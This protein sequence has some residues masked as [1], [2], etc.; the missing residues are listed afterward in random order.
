[1]SVALSMKAAKRR[2]TDDPFVWPAWTQHEGTLGDVV[3]AAQ[4]PGGQGLLLPETSEPSGLGLQQAAQLAP[5]PRWTT[6]YRKGVPPRSRMALWLGA[7]S[8]GS[9]SAF[10]PCELHDL[11][12]VML[13]CVSVSSVKWEVGGRL[14]AK[15]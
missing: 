14:H 11:A 13:T 8:L 1:M 9:N 4:A 3:S 6:G 2:V 15:S 12:Q 7:G 10:T 5:Q